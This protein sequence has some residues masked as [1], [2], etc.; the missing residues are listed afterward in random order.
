VSTENNLRIL[1]VDDDTA[2]LNVLSVLLRRRGYQVLHA[3]DGEAAWGILRNEKVNLVISD[4]LM[5]KLTG[6]ELCR[7]IRAAEFGHYIYVILCTSKGAKAD[8]IEGMDAGAD[9]FLVKPIGT[10]ELR[11]RVR[12]GERVLQL[13]RGLADRNAELA[14][15]NT[16]LRA[17]YARIEDDL[18]A[19]AWMQAN[20]LPPPAA[21]KSLGVSCRWHF[22]PSSY[23]AGDI[24]NFF[25][26][27]DRQLM[28]YMLDVSGH[29]VPSAML[30][31]TLSLMLTPDAAHGSPVKKYDPASGSFGIATPEEGIRELNRRFQGRDDMY[32]TMIYGLLD[33]QASVLRLAQAGHPSPILIRAN[34][35]MQL[36]GQGGMPVGLWPDIEFDTIEVPFYTGDRLLLYSDGVTECMSPERE[37]FG[38]DRL[39]S[40]LRDAGR[41]SLEDLLKRLECVLARWRGG[42]TFDDDV[43]VL[44]LE[45]G[46]VVAEGGSPVGGLLELARQVAD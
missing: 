1:L 39:L 4:W 42:S 29:G 5:P 40:C 9:D 24:F 46:K 7:R 30:S 11:G 44:A 26:V 34:G 15:A 35:E 45:L 25:Q 36:L 19:A 27:D 6:I 17:A 21:V 2:V 32:F 10:E 23:V 41:Q 12:A 22:Q 43:T 8:L 33:P 37:L 31:V 20:L 28:F 38:E 13:E 16:R 18:K 3:A 14:S